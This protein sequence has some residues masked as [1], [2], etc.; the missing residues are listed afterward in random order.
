MR[1]SR[2]KKAD[3][4][5]DMAPLID[6]VF[7]LLVFYMLTSSFIGDL[8]I[9]VNLPSAE[10]SGPLE[11]QTLTVSIDDAGRIF[12]NSEPLKLEELGTKLGPLAAAARSKPKAMVSASGRAS[13]ETLVR[14]MD[15]LNAAGIEALAIET[16]VLNEQ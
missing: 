15:I 12:L 3:F 8:G 13:V 10:T 4:T 5:L 14:V 2:A 6:V 9:E 1:V 11:P 16:Q 7:L